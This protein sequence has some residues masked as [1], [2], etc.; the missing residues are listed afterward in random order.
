[1]QDVCSMWMQGL[2]STVRDCIAFVY[3]IGNTL[4]C[5]IMLHGVVRYCIALYCFVLYCSWC[6]AAYFLVVLAQRSI[7]IAMT[8][9]DLELLV[10]R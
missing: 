3:R 10:L 5:C 9:P 8:I 2:P 6:S 1:M 7:L 4:V